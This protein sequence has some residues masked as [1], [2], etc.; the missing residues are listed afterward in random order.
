[1]L[2]FGMNILVLSTHVEPVLSVMLNGC[3]CIC[4]ALCFTDPHLKF[5][6][7]VIACDLSIY[8]CIVLLVLH[9]HIG[10]AMGVYSL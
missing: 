3:I 5:A 10:L 2:C 9:C 1:M 7:T 8:A 6:W 4:L